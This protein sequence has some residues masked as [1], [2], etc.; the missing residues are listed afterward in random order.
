MRLLKPLF[1]GVRRD[2][3]ELKHSFVIA[4]LNI[5]LHPAGI[6]GKSTTSIVAVE[7]PSPL[8]VPSSTSSMRMPDFSNVLVDNYLARCFI[9][10]QNSLDK[11]GEKVRASSVK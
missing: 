10:D 9:L 2:L 8:P 11:T 5:L 7:S 1:R 3:H 6:E 4:A